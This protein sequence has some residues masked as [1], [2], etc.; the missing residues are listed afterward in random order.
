MTLKKQS[1]EKFVGKVQ[2]TGD[3]NFLFS[4]RVQGYTCT[5]FGHLSKAHLFLPYV[6]WIIMI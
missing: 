1:L 2:N 3:Q 6:I 4:P 5:Y